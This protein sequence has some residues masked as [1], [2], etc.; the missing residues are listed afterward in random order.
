MNSL[1]NDCVKCEISK[2]FVEEVRKEIELLKSE[3]QKERTCICHLEIKISPL[4]NDI[5]LIAQNTA[6]KAMELIKDRQK[7][8]IEI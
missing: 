3:L 7:Q 1:L 4:K 2:T 6:K 5:S 8:R